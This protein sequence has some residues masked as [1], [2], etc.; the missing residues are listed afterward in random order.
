MFLLLFMLLK[1]VQLHMIITLHDISYIN[2][3]ILLKLLKYYNLFVLHEVMNYYLHYM[4][5]IVYK[6]M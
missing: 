6:I 1:H 5:I 4:L 3:K 2:Y